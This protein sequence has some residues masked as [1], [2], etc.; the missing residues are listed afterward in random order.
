LL[1]LNEES[2]SAVYEKPGSLKVGHYI[3]G[4]RIPIRSDD[5]LFG[6]SDKTQPLLNLA[7]H[8]PGEIRG[9][10]ASHGYTGPIID[11]LNAKDFELKGLI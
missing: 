1:G 7:W 11:I 3:P 2:I 10:L 4:T 9:Y 8:I 6:L 5:E